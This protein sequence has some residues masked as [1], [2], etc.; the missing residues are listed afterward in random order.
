MKKDYIALKDVLETLQNYSD[1]KLKMSEVIQDY[2]NIMRKSEVKADLN[3]NKLVIQYS[4][5]NKL[6]VVYDAPRKELA[7]VCTY[8]EY[9]QDR[10]RK[11]NKRR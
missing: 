3:N 11:N 10:L 2:R 6:Y 4:I 8:D 9:E 5:D 1:G 7:Y